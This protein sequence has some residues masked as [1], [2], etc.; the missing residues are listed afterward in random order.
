M[1][2]VITAVPV[3]LNYQILEKV[4]RLAFKM[5]SE[6]NWS[7]EEGTIYL[8]DNCINDNYTM[9]VINNALNLYTY[10]ITRNDPEEQELF[11]IISNDKL[12]NPIKYKRP[13]FPGVYRVQA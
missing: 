2:E 10:N 4:I 12:S 3:V 6:G 13:K 5:V 11:R 7:K 8:N 1:M 9:R